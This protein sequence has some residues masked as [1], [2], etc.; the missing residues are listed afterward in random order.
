[1]GGGG[2]QLVVVRHGQ[3]GVCGSVV[4]ITMY[5]IVIVSLSEIKSVLANLT[6]FAKMATLRGRY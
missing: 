1:M 6:V 3:D 5:I 2:L 4:F